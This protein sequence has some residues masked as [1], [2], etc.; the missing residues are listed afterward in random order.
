MVERM[1]STYQANLPFIVA[2]ARG[3]PLQVPGQ[4]FVSECVVGYASLDEYI[5]RGSIYRYT[6]DMDL[7]VHPEYQHGNVA[8]CLLDRMLHLV[9]NSY[10]SK[11]GYDWVNDGDYLNTGK[12][13]IVKVINLSV[14]HVE[15]ANMEWMGNFL[16]KFE[17]RKAGHL[18]RVGYKAGMAYVSSF[19]FSLFQNSC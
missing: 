16:K 8:N 12:M 1:N 7:Y 9:S 11:G 17:F 13:R 18:M 4:K 15:G 19:P 3:Q 6:F 5:H 2:I 14:P 10:M